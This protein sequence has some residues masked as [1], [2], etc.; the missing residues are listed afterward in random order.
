MPT[1]KDVGTAIPP[2]S[3]ATTCIYHARIKTTPTVWNAFCPI[4]QSMC[5]KRSRLQ[6][7]PFPFIFVSPKSEH[8]DTPQQQSKPKG[9][10]DVPLAFPSATTV[11]R[12][13]RWAFDSSAT[14]AIRGAA[15]CGRCVVNAE[16]KPK[17]EA[18]TISTRMIYSYNSEYSIVDGRVF[19]ARLQAPAISNNWG[20][21]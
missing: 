18:A 13:L 9:Q 15:T 3:T 12:R 2:C 21:H 1:I 20:L 17:R 16:A 14:P 5:P 6:Q 4:I 8:W 7:T 10:A 19:F 11:E